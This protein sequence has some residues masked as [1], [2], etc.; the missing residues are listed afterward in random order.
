MKYKHFKYLIMKTKY[1]FKTNDSEICYSIEYFNNYME[2]HNLSEME[3]YIAIPGIIGDG[4]FWCK[5]HL[6]CGDT[7]SE[8]CGKNNC[9]DYE[10]RNKISGV[11]K[12]HTHWLH[13]H[14][15]K[16]TLKYKL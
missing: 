16:L 1:Y 9:N 6:F 3:V 4:V 10:P 15:D 8:T 7:T 14:G 13:S 12:H 2:E 11:C 5:E